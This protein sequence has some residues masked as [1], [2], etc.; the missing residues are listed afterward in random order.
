MKTYSFPHK[1]ESENGQEGKPKWKPLRIQI[2]IIRLMSCLNEN[3]AYT[4]QT[5]HNRCCHKSIADNQSS[6]TS[7]ESSNKFA[8]QF[9]Y[10][11]FFI[12]NPFQKFSWYFSGFSMSM[13]FNIGG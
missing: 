8:V 12:K 3:K 1:A 10:P 7:I 4:F 13:Y 11:K 6:N 5:C 9:S 2:K